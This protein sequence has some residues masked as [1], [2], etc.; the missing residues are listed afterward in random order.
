MDYLLAHII[1]ASRGDDVE[2]WMNIL[3]VVVLA[4][5]WAVAGIFKAR[6][7]KPQSEDEQESSGK[8]ARPPKSLAGSLRQQLLEQLYGPAGPPEG[9]PS[10]P[11]P[12][13]PA[14]GPVAPPHADRA[15]AQALRRAAPRQPARARRTD[16]PTTR[17]PS[18]SPSAIP[19]PE[20][21]PEIET[22]PDHAAATEAEPTPSEDLA[23][24]LLDYGD[25]DEL[26]RA[27]LHYEIL[28]RPLSLRE[29][30]EHAI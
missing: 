22:L 19:H 25:P 27:I 10:G 18:R 2:G 20:A 5:F 1:L 7:R 4:V 11:A 24:I 13:A 26:R 21:Q 12:D 6:A 30:Q 3:F 15:Y 17:K 23:E 9:K 29:S 16:M 28:G 14:P 8:P